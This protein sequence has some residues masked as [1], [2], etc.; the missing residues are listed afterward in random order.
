MNALSRCAL[1]WIPTRSWALGGLTALAIGLNACAAQGDA[2]PGG[3]KSEA[4][5]S[6]SSPGDK[7]P[8]SKSGNSQDPSSKS[9]SK[10]KGPS[11]KADDWFK[12]PG[13]CGEGCN[14]LDPDACGDQE[15]CVSWNCAIDPK[16]TQAWDDSNCRK[17]GEKKRGEECKRP[18]E[19]DLEN[20]CGKGLMCWSRCRELCEGERSNPTCSKKDEACMLSNHG[21]V[22]ACLPTCDPLDPECEADSPVCVPNGRLHNAFVCVPGGQVDLGGYGA[23]CK[24]LNECAPGHYC[25]EARFVKDEKCKGDYCCTE[26]CDLKKKGESCSDSEAKC[27]PFFPKKDVPKGLENIGVCDSQS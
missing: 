9:G 25:I 5:P 8:G 12:E 22:A 17:I 11:G 13:V 21:F 26:Y 3:E 20:H 1:A 7:S 23:S 2:S 15:R 27:T 14:I 19:G 18:W 16:P 6:E 4:T 10:S 24:N